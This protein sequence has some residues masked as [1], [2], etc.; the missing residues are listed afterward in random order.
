MVKAA[1]AAERETCRNLEN[2]WPARAKINLFLH[3]TGRRADGF[4]NLH[5]LVVF[6]DLA[7]TITVADSDELSLSVTGPFAAGLPTDQNNLVLRAATLLA[8]TAGTT[9]RG[10]IRL[11]KNLPIAAG[12]GGGSADAAAT[13]KALR[14]LWRVSMD[15]AGLL[16]LSALLGADVP[17]CLASHTAIIGGIGHDLVPAPALP[18]FAL[19]LVNPNQTLSTAAVFSHLTLRPPF[20]PAPIWP[21]DREPNFVAG[22]A[23]THNALEPAAQDLAPVIGEVLA[24][25][26]AL[27]HCRLARMSG[28]G[29][30][31]FGLFDDLPSAEMAGR[32][33]A[34]HSPDW[35]VRASAVRGVG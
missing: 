24:R 14:N 27:P 33:L 15:D 32:Q 3:V 23:Q 30:T 2:S 6:A 34:T 9:A 4:H 12:I 31:C 1:V 5:S 22:L 7:D 19:L 16:A 21:D 18:R 35:W 28:S 26:A 20:S 13:L 29:A 8:E 17:V 25:L 11:Q 10:R